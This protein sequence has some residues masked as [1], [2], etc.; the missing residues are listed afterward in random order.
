M[1]EVLN[2]DWS[3][4]T[5]ANLYSTDYVIWSNDASLLPEDAG[6]TMDTSSNFLGLDAMRAAGMELDPYWRMV[7]A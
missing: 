1:C 4:E 2:A 5:L 6:G 7:A 3:T